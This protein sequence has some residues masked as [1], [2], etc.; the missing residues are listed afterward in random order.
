MNFSGSGFFTFL[1]F[2]SALT[3][4]DL[5]GTLPTQIG[6][7]KNLL[8]RYAL[9]IFFVSK[10]VLF[11]RQ[12]FLVFAVSEIVKCFMFLNQCFIYSVFCSTTTPLKTVSEI[13]IIFFPESSENF[14][15]FF[16]F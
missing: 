16:S 15:L 10:R 7:L 12:I 3:S 5:S 13:T 1:F 8:L 9:F 4:V 11:D 6:K 2:F 14:F